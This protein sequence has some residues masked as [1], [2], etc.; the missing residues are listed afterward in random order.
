MQLVA[1]LRAERLSGETTLTRARDIRSR[2]SVIS[3]RINLDSA[4]DRR[5]INLDSRSYNNWQTISPRPRVHRVHRDRTR[6]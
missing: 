6:S 4:S 5:L 3:R 1:S 2:I